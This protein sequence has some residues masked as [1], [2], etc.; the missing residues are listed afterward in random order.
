[1]TRKYSPQGDKPAIALSRVP[2][3]L[4]LQSST[5]HMHLMPVHTVG[6]LSAQRLLDCTRDPNRFAFDVRSRADPRRIS[7]ARLSYG[8]V[9]F[10]LMSDHVRPSYARDHFFLHSRITFLP[11]TFSCVAP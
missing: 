5:V 3:R 1:M 11:P 8:Q 6:T 10:A 7:G 4:W 2:C 9:G